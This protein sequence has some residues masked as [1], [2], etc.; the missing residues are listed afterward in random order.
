[1]LHL[2]AHGH[3]AADHDAGEP[4]VAGLGRLVAALAGA[5]AVDLHELHRL[6]AG[7]RQDAVRRAGHGVLADLEECVEALVPALEHGRGRVARRHQGGA[8][9]ELQDVDGVVALGDLDPR[10]AGG[11][12]AVD[13]GVDLAGHERA[14]PLVER[15]PG[16]VHVPVGNPAHAFE[17]G[18][19]EDLHADTP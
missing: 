3:V 5:D 16:L 18:D 14:L 8:L 15:R 1:M 7:V 4:V 12:R 2:A 9:V 13:G 6:V 10:G 11:K 17:I 19:D